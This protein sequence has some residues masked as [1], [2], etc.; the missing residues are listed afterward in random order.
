ME[1]HF[2]FD[3]KFYSDPDNSG[4]EEFA[5]ELYQELMENNRAL[6]REFEWYAILPQDATFNPKSLNAPQHD[7]EWEYL[8]RYAVVSDP[9]F[10]PPF[11]E[12]RIE[13]DGEEVYRYY[14]PL[15]AEQSC[16]DCHK[17]LGRL[18]RGSYLKK[19]DLLALMRVEVNQKD[20]QEDIAMYIAMMIT[21]AVI[22][23]VLSMF[24]LWF[25]IRYVIVKPVQHLRD[26]ANAVR[27]GDIDQRAEIHTGDEFEELAGAFNRMLRQLL[28]QQEALQD[29]N[30]KLDGKIDQLAQLN[31]QL[32]EM[33]RLKSDFLK[34]MSHELRT[35][36]NS[37]LGFI[38]VLG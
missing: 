10:D 14:K 30:G 25:I 4:D 20:T 27:E 37:I 28:H 16:V 15:Y 21:V 11:A 36:L 38:E 5:S 24:L 29:V 7:Y 23:F 34:T 8:N 13:V 17:S 22:I 1:S 26:V 3:L 18:P 19:G 9:P 6:G 32:F 12:K 31:L 2:Q 35:P 33:N